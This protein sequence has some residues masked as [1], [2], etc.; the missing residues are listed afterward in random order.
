MRSPLPK[1][2]GR[3]EDPV[4]KCA[5]AARVAANKAAKQTKEADKQKRAVE[6]SV[7]KDKLAAMEVD[8]S[9]VREQENHGRV[10]RQS[11]MVAAGGASS[12]NESESGSEFAGLLEKEFSSDKKKS[13]N[14]D[15]EPEI[16]R[17]KSCAKVSFSN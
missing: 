7:T 15:S 1:R 16:L 11:D 4:G 2:R 5:K 14:D 6:A 9:F 8:E 12:G 3:N 10:R 17:K 13:S